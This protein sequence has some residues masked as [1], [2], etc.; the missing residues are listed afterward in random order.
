MIYSTTSPSDQDMLTELRILGS[1]IENDRIATNHSIKPR[2]KIQKPSLLRG[3]WR[4]INSESRANNIIFIQSLLNSVVEKYN[5]AESQGNENLADRIKV[6]T[7]N[8]IEGIKKLQRTYED[9]LQFQACMN[10]SIETVRIHLNIIEN[11]TNKDI[12]EEEYN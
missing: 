10:V 12:E 9:D 2:V 1:I 5:G 3:V 11:E 6:E 8:A 7:Q 4:M